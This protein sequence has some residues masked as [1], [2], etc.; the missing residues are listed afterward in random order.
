MKCKGES[1]RLRAS[2]SDG[3][4]TQESYFRYREKFTVDF[5]EWMNN[6]GNGTH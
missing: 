2:Q 3:K 1:V 4:L 5:Q 6:D